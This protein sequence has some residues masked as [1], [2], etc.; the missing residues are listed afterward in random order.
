MPSSYQ[1]IANLIATY[2][3]VT[4]DGDFAA[5]GH[6]FRHG[7]LSLNGGRPVSGEAGVTDLARQ[8][9]HTYEDGTL[10]T[11][12][13]TTN[14]FIDVDEAAGTAV[15]RSYFTV[16]QSLPDLPLQPIAAGHYGD[17][18]TR[19]GPGWRFAERAVST[20][21]TGDVSHHVRQAKF[22]GG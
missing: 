16:F 15:S 14:L 5:L 3:F 2:A 6:L 13:V 9:L 19:A 21:F 8:V 4:D 22:L 12:H 17:L 20:D 18:F 7:S 11:R 10:K 1:E